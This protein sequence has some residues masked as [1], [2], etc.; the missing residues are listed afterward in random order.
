MNTIDQNGRK[1]TKQVRQESDG[2]WSAVV[3]SGLG[4]RANPA[5]NIRRQYGYATR[6]DAMRADISKQP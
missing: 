5:C 1:V 6:A 4:T 2:K 3:W